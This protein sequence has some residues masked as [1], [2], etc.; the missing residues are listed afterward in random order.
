VEKIQKN[1][2]V[3]PSGSCEVEPAKFLIYGAVI[4]LIIIATLSDKGSNKKFT[5]F[6]CLFGSAGKGGVGGAGFRIFAR[7]NCLG[8]Y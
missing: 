2:L 5:T 6:N 4:T 3:L 8:R 1:S 7:I